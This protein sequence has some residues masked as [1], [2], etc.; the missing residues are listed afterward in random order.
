MTPIDWENAVSAEQRVIR[1]FHEGKTKT[2]E[3]DYWLRFYGID[4]MEAIYRKYKAGDYKLR[5]TSHEKAHQPSAQ[6]TNATTKNT[7]SKA[8]S[9]VERSCPNDDL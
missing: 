6:P 4:R 9:F 8:K 7:Y 1:L 3:F 2:Q 5:D